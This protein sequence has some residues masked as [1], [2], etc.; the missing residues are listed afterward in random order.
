[1]RFPTKGSGTLR[2]FDRFV[3]D[4]HERLF[5]AL[6]FITG[7]RQDAEDL[8]Q[9][10]FLKLWERWDRIDQ[11]HDPTGYLFRVALNG[12]RMQRRR[13]TMA[14][15][16]VLPTARR[17]DA[18]EEVEQHTDLRRL[19]LGLTP[20]Q[21]AAILLMDLL[22]YASDEAAQILGVRSSTVRTLASQARRA[23]KAADGSSDA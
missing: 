16:K 17:S 21:R 22:G 5:K 14:A 3:E 11:I 6:Y 13:A 8:A 9:D 10:A 7:N 18:F 20:R 1:M 23:I 12:F 2:V 15:R 4:E 19:L